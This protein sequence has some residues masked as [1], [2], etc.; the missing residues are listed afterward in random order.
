MTTRIVHWFNAEGVERIEEINRPPNWNAM[1][2]Y[3][4]GY[5]EH[6]TVLYKGQSTAM[7][8]HEEGRMRWQVRNEAASEIYF[9]MS[10]SQGIDPEDPA[11]AEEQLLAY[12]ASMGITP[13]NIIRT[14]V[15]DKKV[16][17]YGPAI[18]LEGFPNE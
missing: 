12:A 10:R 1:V 6:I 8:V 3:I 2:D 16:G 11:Q 14:G 9:A 5:L 15:D 4:G 17:I 18:L 13:E 7:W